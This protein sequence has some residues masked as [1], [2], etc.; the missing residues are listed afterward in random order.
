MA[1]LAAAA[2]HIA[3]NPGAGLHVLANGLLA[4]ACGDKAWVRAYW[5]HG[6]L[7][8][9]AARAGWLPADRAPLPFP[10]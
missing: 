9:R 3:A 4:G 7:L 1:S 8:A 6:R 10:V 5:S 2:A